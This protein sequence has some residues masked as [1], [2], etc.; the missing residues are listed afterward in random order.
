MTTTGSGAVPAL[1]ELEVSL[2]GPG[3]GE[4]VA[5]HL[6]SN[7]WLVVDSC[8]PSG[9]RTPAALAYLQQI[10]VDVASA[11]KIIVVTH[12]HDD[13]IA[14]IS[15]V[16]EAA[17]SAKLYCSAALNG[18]EFL[19]F[20]MLYRKNA[21]QRASSGVDEMYEV[22]SLLR[23]TRRAVG[24]DVRSVGPEW[25][26]A[27]ECLWRR[28]AP[29]ASLHALSP[30]AGALTLALQEFGDARDTLMPRRRAVAQTPN[31]VAVAL[32]IE[33][34][35]VRVLL[36]SDLE[37]SS[38][39]NCGWQAIVASTAKPPGKAHVLKVPHHGSETAHSDD[40]WRFMLEPRPHA[41]LTTFTRGKPLPTE[42]DVQRLRGLS[43]SLH[44]TTP[45]R[46]WSPP[47]RDAAVDR[48]VKEAVKNRRVLR[49]QMGHVRLRCKMGQPTPRFDIELLGPALELVA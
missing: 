31:E 47:R 45:P 3:I 12:W 22:L 19:K 36:G 46:G 23:K 39:P 15:K 38:D 44:A 37:E 49:G 32:W 4:S 20:V 13:H 10:G 16:L 9:S 17:P 40:V 48:T 7:E 41:I 8:C 14:G 42:A 5:V 24:R 43:G 1:D 21:M 27:N 30:S 25:V 11:V 2:F 34:G 35:G 28:E 33:V 18:N 26:K 29:A 6:G